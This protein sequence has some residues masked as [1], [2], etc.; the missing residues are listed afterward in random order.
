MLRA[1]RHTHNL[2]NKEQKLW[3]FLGF[4]NEPRY[5]QKA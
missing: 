3:G 1:W 2:L 5:F 4:N